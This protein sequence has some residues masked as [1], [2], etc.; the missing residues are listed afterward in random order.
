M[1]LVSLAVIGKDNEPLYL[2]D[3]VLSKSVEEE[4]Q[5]DENIDAETDLGPTSPLP[6][7]SSSEESLLGGKSE[8]EDDPFGFFTQ[9]LPPNES[10]SLRHQFMIHAALDRFEEL[11]LVGDGRGWRTP[12]SIG[13]NAMWVGLLCPI[14]EMCI[15]GYLTNTSIKF[16]AVIE[17]THDKQQQQ[18]RESDL[19]NLF[20][21]LHDYY[22]EHTLNPFSKIRAKISSKRFD[23]GVS[24]SV[25]LFN[26]DYV[27]K[28]FW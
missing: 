16:I 21:I 20:E 11:T 5:R 7:T 4:V 2:R 10:S 12:G 18:S 8:E 23:D 22:V 25:G 1:A 15:Y 19:K 17:D 14:E 26:K 6:K 13:T 27:S 3:F 24:K 28:E 9:E